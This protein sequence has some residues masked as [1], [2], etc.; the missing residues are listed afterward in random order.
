MM[1]LSSARTAGL[2]L[3]LG[4]AGV[5]PAAA[6]DSPPP[7]YLDPDQPIERRVDDLLSRMTL[8]EKVSQMMNAAPAIPRL[9][10]PAYD[11][12]NECLHGVA[13]AGVATVF[14][15]AIG[16]AA[17]WDQDLVERMADVISTEARAKH[18]DA[19]R[20]GVHERYLGLTMWSPNINIFRDPRWGRGQETYGEDPYLAGRIGVAFVKGLQG[21]DPHYLKVISTPKHYAVH[22]GPEP[23]RHA[24]DARTTGRDLWETYLPA[25]EATVREA[26]A[27]SVMCAYNS[28]EGQP[29][30]AHEELLGE[31]LRKRWGFEGYVVSDCG[32]IT[33]IWRDHKYR[34]T[35]AEAAAVAVQRGCDLECGW[36]Y[37]SLG[38]AVGEGLISEAELD[39]ALRRLFTARFRLGMF[40]PPER[41]PYAQIPISANDAPEHRAL[42]RQ[43]ATASIVLLKNAGGLL[44]ITKDVGTVAVI[45]PNADSVPVLLGNYNGTPSDP[46]TALEGIRRKLPDAQV[47]YAAGSALADG[48]PDV[49]P[50]GLLAPAG[51]SDATRGL[52]AEYFDNPNLEGTPR[53]RRVDEQV[54]FV[55]R[56]SDPA[57]GVSRTAF[58]VRWTGALV[59]ERSGTV[60]LGVAADDSMRLWVD[61]QLLVD[62]WGQRTRRRT[63]LASVDLVAG[64]KHSIRL[65]YSHTGYV[66]SVRL[67]W[68]DP[69]LPDVR[70][71]E[72]VRLARRSDVAIL[73][74][75]ISAE[76]E[77]EEMNVSAEGFAG[78]D[79]TSLDLPATQQKLL[80]AVH[81]TGTPVVLVLTSGSA[82]S[83][84]WAAEHVPAIVEAWYGGEEGGNA[85]A[86]VLFGDVS[87]AGRL[88]VTFYRSVDQLPPFDDYA[89]AGRTYRYFR[90]EPLFPF[91]HGLSY[92]QFRYHDLK[93]VCACGQEGGCAR[94]RCP[95]ERAGRAKMLAG[96]RGSEPAVGGLAKPAGV[97]RPDEDFTASVTVEN[98]GTRGGDEVIQLYVRDIV[99]SLPVPIR[100]L[101]GFRRV[102]LEAGQSRRVSFTLTPAQ[103]GVVQEDGRRVLEPGAFRISVGGKQPG[104][105]G[106]AD[107]PTTEVVTAQFQILAAERTEPTR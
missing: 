105:S 2:L 88:P 10:V 18:H 93:L 99:A 69:Q 25:F 19:L 15:Q 80:E 96:H 90:G 46:V 1:S 56:A 47:L 63:A 44:P 102:H 43:V 12:W 72:A 11:W 23:L 48:I 77:G 13:R 7:L 24:F 103:L 41:V 64:K 57:P 34:K 75:G 42:A 94:K 79:R 71:A 59:A 107:A 67:V 29:A 58:S 26:G 49:V 9:G 70:R 83:V 33:N 73:A 22:S 97:F 92:A 54:D 4:L 31:I 81:A 6:E 52:D 62:Q 61:G 37:R 8:E 35:P 36:D 3:L 14:P 87:P 21:D 20:R 50:A 55:W 39:I 38:Q 84:G 60:Q 66:P 45:G 17:T 27:F 51:S 101:V 30:C 89:M 40:D 68:I 74:L 106:M 82:L 5:V 16:L 85:L 100:S 76:L 91:G 95:A 28:Y 78:G 53:A 98:V 86:D 65:E 32:A 104:F